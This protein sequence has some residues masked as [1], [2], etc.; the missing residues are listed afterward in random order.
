MHALYSDGI[1]LTRINYGESDRIVT[2][3]T[4]DFGKV[5]LIARGVRKEKSKL[6]GG[7]ELFCTSNFGFVESRGELAVLTSSRLNKYYGSFVSD[8]SRVDFAYNALKKI[9][10]I[11]EERVDAS[12]YIFIK[13]LLEALEIIDIPLDLI[14]IWWFVGLAKITGHSINVTK[15]IN[16]DSFELNQN[17]TFLDNKGSFKVVDTPGYTPDHIKLLRLVADNLPQK[18]TRVKNG[19]KLAAELIPLAQG[20]VE[21]V[22]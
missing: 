20:F 16:A 8:L 9:N 1:V 3:L 13:Q 11:T 14:E 18:L 22:H 7:I 10:K 19:Q 21:Y 2:V 12:Y 17:Y 4:K 15:P 5:K 6:A